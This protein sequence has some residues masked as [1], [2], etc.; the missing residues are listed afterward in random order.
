MLAPQIGQNGREG[1]AAIQLHVPVAA[2]DEQAARAERARQVLEQEQCRPI[3]PVEIVEDQEDRVRARGV[4]EEGRDALEEPVALLLGS[5]LRRGWEVGQALAD[6]RDQLGHVGCTLAELFAQGVLGAFGHV[7]ADRLHEGQIGEA[8]LRLVAAAP[9]QLGAAQLCVGRELA[10]GARLSHPRLSHQHDQGAVPAQ[11]SVERLAQD[12]HLFL[13]THEVTARESRGSGHGGGRPRRCARRGP[14]L[15]DSA[16][17]GGCGRRPLRRVLLQKLEDQ[18]FQ[19]RGD[20]GVVPGRCD[21]PCVQVLADDR[22]AVVPDEGRSP[23][24]HLVEHHTQRVEVGARCDVPSHRLLGR[25]VGGGADDG[26]LL[27]EPR[28]IQRERQTEIAQ[29]RRTVLGEPDIPRLEIAVDDR[30][31]VRVLEGDADLLGD[32]QGFLDGQAMLRRLAQ[33][34]LEVAARHVLAHDVELRALLAHVVD[35]DD[36][37]LVAE[38]SHRLRL[39]PYARE[40]RLVET[41]GLDEGEGHVASDQRVVCQ[42][43]PLLAALAEKALHPVAAGGEGARSAR[44]GHRLDPG[45]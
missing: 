42:V 21:G 25:H 13:P 24:Q 36:V 41:L 43:D 12:L 16:S 23:G 35:G 11:R 10:A 29:H 5:A 28:A 44:L 27:G 14:N 9:E 17:H 38:P 4:E 3:R 6:L 31:C 15:L 40:P 26:A 39:A 20:L 34:A 37:G 30:P 32:A 19:L 1:V 8:C 18:R 33:A 22:D 7:L 2:H 45:P